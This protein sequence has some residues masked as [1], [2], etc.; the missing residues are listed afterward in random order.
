MSLQKLMKRSC[1][2]FIK[3]ELTE[4]KL[5][6][7]IFVT[8]FGRNLIVIKSLKTLKRIDSIVINIQISAI[9]NCGREFNLMRIL[10][11]TTITYMCLSLLTDRKVP[12]I[13]GWKV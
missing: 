5:S 10:N 3:S 13:V 6:I 4:H 12:T 8:K 1:V 2:V 7:T 11:T 9:Q